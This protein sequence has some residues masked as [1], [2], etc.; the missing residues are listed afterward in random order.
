MCIRAPVTLV[1]LGEGC[2]LI[3]G[4]GFANVLCLWWY[5]VVF[6]DD[7]YCDRGDDD[8]VFIP[9]EDDVLVS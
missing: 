8:S 4:F 9:V 3:S 2:F 1:V 6:G 5:P 7:L